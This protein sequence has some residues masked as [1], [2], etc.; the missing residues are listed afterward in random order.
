[1]IRPREVS[2]R[3]KRRVLDRLPGQVQDEE[4]TVS[5]FWLDLSPRRT[6]VMRAG[7]EQLLVMELAP[8]TPP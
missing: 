2:M 5:F 8:Y 7:I 4:R 6:V 3:M 1:M